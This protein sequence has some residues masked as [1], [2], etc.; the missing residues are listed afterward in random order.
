MKV[1]PDK[2]RHAFGQLSALCPSCVA[3]QNAGSTVLGE[4][5]TPV[6]ESKI[7]EVCATNQ[8]Q[9][10]VPRA[11]VDQMH[12]LLGMRPTHAVSDVVAKDIHAI[13][14]DVEQG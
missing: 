2:P 12:V 11:S 6:V 13:A 14:D 7:L 5:L 1:S 8:Y 10:F 4:K 3:K 9:L